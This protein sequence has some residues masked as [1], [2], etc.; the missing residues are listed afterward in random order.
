MR[1]KFKIVSKYYENQILFAI[2]DGTIISGP[3]IGF[4]AELVSQ[5]SWTSSRDANGY[6]ICTNRITRESVWKRESECFT[7]QRALILSLKS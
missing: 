7:S 2:H 4:Q 1:Q 6:E 5:K 3:C